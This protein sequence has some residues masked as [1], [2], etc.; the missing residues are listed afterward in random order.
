MT[1]SVESL[2]NTFKKARVYDL[3]QLRYPGMPGF[4]PVRPS[5]H[6]FLYRHH[7]SYYVPSKNGPRTSASGLIVMTDQSGTHIDARCHQASDLTLFDGTKITPEVETPWGFAKH[8]ASQLPVFITRGVLVDVAK[9]FG[10]PLP[11]NHEITLN[12]FK[13]ALARE[14]VEITKESIV[15]VRTGYGRFWND[16]EKY[17][18][19]A[20]VSKEVSIYLQDK[21]IGVGADN[22]AW[23]VPSVRDPE[24]KSQLAAHLHLLARKGIYIIENINLEDLSKDNVYSFIFVGLPPKF[25]GATGSPFR[26]IAIVP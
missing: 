6:Y 11:E 14:K 22:L 16:P 10:D 1:D 23:D 18:N 15:F 21:C 4:E 5:L 26:P 8:D 25:K 17:E 2:L 24:T 20:G 13:E 12:E 9:F 19:A 3:E 7:E